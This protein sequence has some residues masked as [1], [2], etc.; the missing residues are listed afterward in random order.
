M[1]MKIERPT[2]L[3]LGASLKTYRYSH[4]AILRLHLSAV[5]TYAFGLKTGRVGDVTIQTSIEEFVDSSIH[6]FSLYLGPDRQTDLLQWVKMIKP[7]R[8]IFNPGTENPSIYHAL[9]KEGVQ[10]EEACTL[11]LLASNQYG[12]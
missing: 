11:V 1:R 3:V 5:P 8:I 10:C 7:Q 2:T 6:T 4:Q 9:A 12:V